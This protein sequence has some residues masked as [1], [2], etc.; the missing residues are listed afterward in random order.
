MVRPLRLVFAPKPKNGRLPSLKT[1]PE[2]DPVSMSACASLAMRATLNAAQS[3]C[4]R[5]MVFPPCSPSAEHGPMARQTATLNFAF[6]DGVRPLLTECRSSNEHPLPD[7][8]GQP[9]TR[10]F[11]D[12]ALTAWPLAGRE[13]VHTLDITP[14]LRD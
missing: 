4:K 2:N 8:P 12:K 1:T 13:Q 6:H 14:Q 10:L 5:R 3:T 11:S 7:Y 9:K